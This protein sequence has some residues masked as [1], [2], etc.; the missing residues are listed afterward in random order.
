MLLSAI[1]IYNSLDSI[2]VGTFKVVRR[3]QD[4]HV[5]KRGNSD[6]TSLCKLYC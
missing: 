2:R 6:A 3:N 4:S 5:L 1:E